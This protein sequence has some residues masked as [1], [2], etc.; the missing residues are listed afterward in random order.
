MKLACKL[1]FSFWSCG[2]NSVG[3]TGLEREMFSDKSSMEFLMI[4]SKNHSS[5]FHNQDIIFVASYS[6]ISDLKDN[7]HKHAY[8]SV[9]TLKE[10]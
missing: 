5:F 1:L 2:L 3:L 9:K 7:Q 4:S 8:T 10:F 6:W